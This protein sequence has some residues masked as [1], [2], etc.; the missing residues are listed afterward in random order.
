MDTVCVA[1]SFEMA[2]T[3]RYARLTWGGKAERFL[4]R[5][6]M[7]GGGERERREK[8]DE[9]RLTYSLQDEIR[10]I[11]QLQRGGWKAVARRA[12]MR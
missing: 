2:S 6:G 11:S 8:G 5:G 10:F 3:S 9:K 1:R 12:A 7:E 4:S